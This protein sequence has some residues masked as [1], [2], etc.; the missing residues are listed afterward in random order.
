MK[1]GSSLTLVPVGGLANRMKAIDAAI[2]L[3]SG[4][5][6]ALKIYWFR[7]K[8]LNCRFDQL[9]QPL[10]LPQVSLIEATSF[11]SFSYD[12]P[13]KRNLY[14]PR[15][16]QL[17]YFDDCVY[18]AEVTERMY[19][20]FD[21][22][23][24]AINKRTYLASCVYFF[25]PAPDARLFQFFHPVPALQQRIDEVSR[26]FGN[27]CVGVHIRRT[28]NLSSINESPTKLFV[29]RMQMMVQS[30]KDTYFYLA[31]DSSEEKRKMK[32][33]FGKRILTSV[34]DLSRNSVQGIQDALVELYVLSKTKM[35]LGSV[36]SSYS[37]TA[38][39]IGQIECQFMKKEV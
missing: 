32:A 25:P 18:E 35:I 33:T 17:F 9:F 12:R 19:Q 29:D 28:D 34:T 21:F 24:W 7:D 38:A 37:E 1:K 4:T 5:D 13:R 20:H 16:F 2:Q 27:R 8:G 10:D 15:L 31:S 22:R 30:D 23:S 36:K 14:I 11:D 39:Q 6:L 26:T 3:I